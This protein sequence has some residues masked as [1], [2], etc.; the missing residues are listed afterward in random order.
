[1]GHAHTPPE[2]PE[3]TDE[4]GDSPKWLPWLGVALF[5]LGI[6]GIAVCH[7]QHADASDDTADS[8]PAEAP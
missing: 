3:I 8:A 4:A 5:A 2:L 1:M 6:G 7:S